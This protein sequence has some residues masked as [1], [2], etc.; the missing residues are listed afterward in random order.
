MPSPP[1]R[2]IPTGMSVSASM[3]CTMMPV[4]GSRADARPVTP[5]VGRREAGVGDGMSRREW[6]T[7]TPPP[8]TST[9]GMREGP[10]TMSSTLSESS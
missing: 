1:V 9:S 4:G 3:A 5:E 8:Q 6:V 7:L 10:G 2:A